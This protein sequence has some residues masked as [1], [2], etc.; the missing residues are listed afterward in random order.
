MIKID[1]LK[2]LDIFVLIIFLLM[3]GA[4][5]TTSIY[6]SYHSEITKA[7][8][9]KVYTLI[10]TNPLAKL[11]L[12]TYGLRVMVGYILLPALLFGSYVFFR[13]R[14]DI[15]NL[16]YYIIIIVFSVLFD[17]L[18]NLGLVIGVLLK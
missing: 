16:E 2:Q 11:S 12:I 4:R 7:D 17:F 8:V 15:V 9:E 14:I 10:E 18:N 1:K 3:L 5:I 13:K 6:T